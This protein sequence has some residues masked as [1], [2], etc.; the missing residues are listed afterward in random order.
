MYNGGMTKCN[1]TNCTN[2]A[3]CKGLCNAHY[4]RERKGKDVNKPVQQYNKTKTCIE[5]GVH[6]GSK[7]GF[8]RC[9]AHYSVYK[10]NL[11]KT[12]LV[13][14]MGGKCSAC[15]GV[16]HISVYDFHHMH[17]KKDSISTML[18]NCSEE[19]IFQEAAK[20]ILLCA[21]CH[22]IHHHAK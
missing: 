14:K 15:N 4:L 2:Q 9:K 19:E 5:C 16:F 13:E 7:G 3:R 11:L 8:L 22:R 6:T 17:D 10:R 1:I 20:C 18:L 12:Q 21:N